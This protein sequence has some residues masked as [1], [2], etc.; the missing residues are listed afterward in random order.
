MTN[1]ARLR[2]SISHSCWQRTGLALALL[3]ALALVTIQPAVA[4][5]FTVLH[6]FT[7]GA[8]GGNPE[9][10]LAVD[11]GGNLYGTASIGGA[12][13]G[14]VFKLTHKNSSWV[15]APLYTFQSGSDGSSPF[16]PLVFGPDGALYGTTEFGGGGPCRSGTGFLGCGTV[17]KL[18]PPQTVCRSVNCPWTETILYRFQGNSDASYPLSRLTF[19]GA[20]NIYGT[21]FEGGTTGQGTVYELVPSNGS[22]SETILHSFSGPDGESP[23]SEVIFDAAGNLYGTAPTGGPNTFGVT[24]ELSPSSSGW[25]ETVLYSPPGWPNPSF[26]YGGV[27][28]G[29][30]GTLFGTALGGGTSNEGAVYQLSRSAG[31][32]TS[33]TL[34]SF[35]G[36]DG[37]P[38]ASLVMDAAGNLYGTTEADNGGCGSV[39]KGTRSG[40]NWTFSNLKVF[41]LTEGCFQWGSVVLDASGNIYGTSYAGGTYTCFAG[42]G[43]CGTVWEITP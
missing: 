21:T 31:G 3:S 4:Q 10:A 24:Y 26:P 22:W 5:T 1:P 35:S 23:H 38:F 42:D 14:L 41:Q 2:R 32:W 25:V 17:F 7:G 33:A 30:V 9:S 39:F 11:A 27:I 34:A 29:P 13:Y 40:S 18:T 37:G 28:F 6:D 16:G 15:L 12:G 43:G 8:D 36:G 20:G 19:D